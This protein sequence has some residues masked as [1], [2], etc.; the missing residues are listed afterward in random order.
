MIAK[1]HI[2][3]FCM[4]YGNIGSFAKPRKSP[5][6]DLRHELQK[7]PHN[8]PDNLNVTL[9]GNTQME[10]YNTSVIAPNHLLGGIGSRLR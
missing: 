9:V 2:D 4:T 7:L 3:F 8:V 5:M 6:L 10:L 1:L